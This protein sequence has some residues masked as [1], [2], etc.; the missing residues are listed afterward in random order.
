MR[1]QS[2]TVPNLISIDIEL[3]QPRFVKYLQAELGNEELR[4]GRRSPLGLLLMELLK[5]KGDQE[6]PRTRASSKVITVKLS[7]DYYRGMDHTLSKEKGKFFAKLVASLFER[8]FIRCVDGYRAQFRMKKV[9]AI[10]FFRGKYDISESE[11]PLE[12]AVKTYDRAKKRSE[13]VPKAAPK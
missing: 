4:V 13:K 3:G 12:S 6:P 11:W 7:E 1:E 9:E 8:D 10:R 2:K 5:W